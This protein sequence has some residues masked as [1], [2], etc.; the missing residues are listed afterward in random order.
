MRCVI[1]FKDI[2]LYIDGRCSE[3]N[4]QAL[5]KHLEE[6]SNCREQAESL[7]ALRSSLAGLAPVKES[8]GF[9][10]EFN[11]LLQ[12]RLDARGFFAQRFWQ[13]LL[14]GLTR[15]RDTFVYPLPVAV[16][17]AA[18]FILVIG[19]TLGAR[20]HVLGKL[21]YVEFV[22][23][24]VKI[25]HQAKEIWIPLQADVRLKAGDKI[26]SR[27]G[28]IFNIVSRGKY[29]ARV[30]DNSII[31]IA[32]IKSGWR[33]IDTDFNI[34]YGNLLVNTAEGF[35][36]S[37][38]NIYT[39]SCDAEVVGTAFIVRA[40]GQETWLGVLEGR[41]K[42]ISKVHPF[43]AESMSRTTAFVSS[44]QKIVIKPYGY[45]SMPE[46]FSEKEWRM[47]QELYQLTQEQRVILLIGT[48]PDRIEE[49]L[50][51]RPVYISGIE[52]IGIPKDI[53]EKISFIADA[54]KVNNYEVIPE[55]IRDLEHF[56]QERSDP[57]YN[58][59]IL[60]FIASHY[61]YMHDYENAIRVFSNI[62]ENHPDSSLASLAQCAVAT[63]YLKDLKDLNQARINYGNLL[64]SYPDSVD[65]IRAKEAL[66]TIR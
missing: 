46:L 19:V 45:P 24:D 29:K 26:H 63:I 5:E 33:D 27:K 37:K 38:M 66:S 30:K 60:M 56:L 50:G 12:G 8:E 13:R 57:K 58:V 21:P 7:K 31:V 41:V 22:A 43:K 39:P 6:C 61:H 35:K 18:T 49:L 51:P 2:S 48:G 11:R 42:V 9:D 17:I 47:M 25:Y 65:A 55:A 10:L 64:K 28:A 16:R 44:G 3:G 32:K 1:K 15:A 40:L 23:G 20:G 14:E 4:K 34:S 36:G 59:E 52:R 62:I 54:I 53:S